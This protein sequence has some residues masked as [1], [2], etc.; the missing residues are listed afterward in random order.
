MNLPSHVELDA[1]LRWVDLLHT[2]NG[3][4]AGTVPSYFEMD[5]RLAWHAAQGLEFSVVGQN[6]LHGR[7]PEYGFPSPTRVEIER[8]VYGKVAWRY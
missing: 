7:H 2:N 8:S 5:T 6:L 4:V 3:P 1:T